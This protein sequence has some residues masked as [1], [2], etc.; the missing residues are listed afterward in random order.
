EQ[1]PVIKTSI[2]A[3][4]AMDISNSTVLGNIQSIVNLL[5]QRGIENPDKVDD[6]EM[7][8]ISEYV[9]HFHG[10]LGTGEWLQVAQLHRAIERSP[11]N[12]M[13]HVI[14]IPG[15]FHLKMACADAIWWTFH[16]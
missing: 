8:D 9:I 7:P 2:I 10:D 12:R 1:I 5:Q 13:Q 6:P 14:F 4:Q 16:Q 3:A 15:L 11:W